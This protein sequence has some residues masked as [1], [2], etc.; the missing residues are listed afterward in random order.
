MDERNGT[1]VAKSLRK[2]K[3]EGLLGSLVEKAAQ[4]ALHKYSKVTSYEKMETFEDVHEYY[5]IKSKLNEL[6]PLDDEYKRIEKKDGYESAYKFYQEN[7]K[8]FDLY[9]ELAEI[10]KGVSKIKTLMKDEPED[11]V[12]DMADIRELR[13]K[14]IDLINNY[15][16]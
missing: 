9:D 16:E 5:E 4:K 6:K 2:E 15:N 8:A 11:P 13:T 14:A 10:E 12:K 7:Q 3:I 1:N